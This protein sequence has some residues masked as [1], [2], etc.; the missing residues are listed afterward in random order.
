M[1]ELF[2]LYKEVRQYFVWLSARDA[3]ELTKELQSKGISDVN[4]LING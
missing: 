1:I 2:R 3:Y 4:W